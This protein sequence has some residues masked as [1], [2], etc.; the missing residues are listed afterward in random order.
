MDKYRFKKFKDQLRVAYGISTRQF[1][2]MKNED[3]SINRKN[4]IKFL[5]KI[6]L[7]IDAVCMGQVHGGE[8]V[9]VKD[10]NKNL[11][12][13]MDGMITNVQ[14]LPLVVVTA[15]CLPII[16]FDPNKNVIGIAHGGRKG[17]QSGIIH[18]TVLKLKS[19][20][21]CET[22]DL[23]V[24]IGPGI[25]KKCYEVD[26]ELID[27]RKSAMEFLIEEGILEANIESIDTC[28]RCNRDDFYSYR[29]DDNT[30]RFATVI[31]LI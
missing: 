21:G 5:K 7:S 29:G 11:I 28:T 16:F 25:E 23:F 2:S 4:L 27:I 1:G 3:N 17:L 14:N 30:D 22:Q 31:S 8:V 15:D 9:S 19:E 26:G 13:N 10:S 24:G 12:K 6:N 20:F 18:N